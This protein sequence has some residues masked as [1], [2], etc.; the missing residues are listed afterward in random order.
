MTFTIWL[1]FFV[2]RKLARDNPLLL[3]DNGTINRA[4]SFD[5]RVFTID[6][7]A[8]YQLTP[9]NRERLLRERAS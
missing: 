8:S 2:V 3:S 9:K 1:P 5:L 4:I 7:G 6:L